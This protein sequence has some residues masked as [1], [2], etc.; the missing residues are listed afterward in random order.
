MRFRFHGMTLAVEGDPR[1]VAAASEL[2][3]ALPPDDSLGVVDLRLVFRPS[4]SRP[5]PA[6]PRS[7]YHGILDCHVDG[8][9][10]VLWDG[11]SIARVRPGGTL[12][13]VDAADESMQD[14]YLFAHVFLLIS[15][16]TALRWHGLFHLHAG[17]LVAPDGRGILVAGGAGAGKSSL[18]LALLEAG[19]TYLGDDAVFLSAR[20]GE[21]A[22]LALPRPFHVAPRT[23]A[24]FPRVGALLSDL[25]PTG[26]KRRL[27]PRLAWP[28]RER[29]SM[30]LPSLLLLPHVSGKATTIVEPL[31]SAEAMGA[32][33]ESSTLVVVD[34][35]P[36]G[37][38]HLEVLRRAADGVRAWRVESGLDLLERPGETVERLLRS[39]PGSSPTGPMNG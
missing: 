20:G 7:F 28:G 36:G 23:A 27:D 11:H 2:L 1:A 8:D 13:D 35:L 29:V 18:T 33:I 37:D 15:L 5:R 6:G 25:L 19:C 24:A 10:L 12:I 38:E 22:V 39:A 30:P 34:G 26:E 17:A 31:S 32:L 3:G 9:D 16:V 4:P 14:G 21:V